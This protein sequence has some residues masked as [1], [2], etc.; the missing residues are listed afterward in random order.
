MSA[1]PFSTLKKLERHYRGAAGFRAVRGFLA[2]N[3]R[4]LCYLNRS[5]TPWAPRIWEHGI[6][7][8]NRDPRR[9]PR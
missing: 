2:R 9:L 5:L 8:R 7:D 1:D 4:K 3:R 6:D